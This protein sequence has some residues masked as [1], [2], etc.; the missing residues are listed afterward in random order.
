Q[1]S[2]HRFNIL[3]RPQQPGA[4]LRE[5]CRYLVRIFFR[6]ETVESC[7]RFQ[8]K[9]IEWPLGA[10]VGMQVKLRVGRRLKGESGRETQ[11][12]QIRQKQS[13]GRRL[14]TGNQKIATVEPGRAD[15]EVAKITPTIRL[16]GPALRGLSFPSAF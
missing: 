11:A 12:P 14:A 15:V 8:Q 5:N 1:H 10:I 3:R 16:L 7:L 4:P 2:L 6:D 9:G 13:G